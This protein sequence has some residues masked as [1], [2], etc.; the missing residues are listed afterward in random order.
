MTTAHSQQSPEAGRASSEDGAGTVTGSAQIEISVSEAVVTAPPIAAFLA[1]MTRTVRMTRLLAGGAGSIL[2]LAA[3]SS[4][5]ETPSRSP[6]SSP[7][8]VVT[9]TPSL[10]PSPSP[11]APPSPTPLP[12]QASVPAGF[13]PN[14]VTFVSLEM[15][16]V[17]GS[18]PCGSGTCLALIRTLNAGRTW[19]AV[20]A[21]PTL[22]SPASAPDP[23]VSQVRFADAHDGWVF[24]PQL[25]STHDGG[26]HWS[27]SSLSGVWSLEAAA[28][29]VHAVVFGQSSDG[30]A[31]ESSVTTSDVWIK[32]GSL[33]TG[34]GPVPASDLVLQGTTGWAIENDR[35]VVGGARLVAGHWVTWRAPCATNGG[36]AV[37]GAATVSSLV[38]VCQQGIWGP[39]GYTGPPAV[40]AYFSGNG[41]ATF[42]GG[43][44]V[45][46]QADASGDVVAS[47]APGVAVTDILTNTQ[48]ALVETVN[49]GASW[50]VVASVSPMAMFTYVGFTSSSQGV[51]IESNGTA[52]AL[53]MTFDGGRIWSPVRF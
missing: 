12:A 3:C 20:Q 6:S 16:W 18:A 49:N 35:T 47:P 17:L 41:G 50:R 2:L 30:F 13:E 24:G 10:L 14:S 43:G 45:P 44:T 40:R 53:L 48:R 39:S 51:A 28:G 46:G 15:G 29:H 31:I 23:G 9:T 37:I 11:T 22:F 33:Q 19:S 36:A 38:A 25:W 1:L 4:A 27:E 52:S 34:A 7:S 42:Y 8:A 5:P 26:A 21:P 32:T